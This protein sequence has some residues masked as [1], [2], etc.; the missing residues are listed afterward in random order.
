MTPEEAIAAEVVRLARDELGFAYQ[1]GPD[2][3]MASR[4]DSLQL[5]SLV[6]AVE[7]RFRVRLD[8]EDA[9]AAR[10]LSALARLLSRKGASAALEVMP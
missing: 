6:V 2:E 7:N 1:G 3:E 9:A 8:E 4:L 5:L 10:T